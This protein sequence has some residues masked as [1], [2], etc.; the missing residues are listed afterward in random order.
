[1]AARRIK[2]LAAGG[3][4]LGGTVALASWVFGDDN[5]TK[6][7]F[8]H[9]L[10]ADNLKSR[11]TKPLPTRSEQLKALED[12]VY[13]VLVIG[14]GATGAG[15]ALDSVSRGLKTAL[16]ELDDFSSGT[17]SR[18]TKLLHGGVRYLQKAIFNL[19]IEQYKM[20]KEALHERANL[21]EIA[22]HL[23][24]PL[25]I[26]LPVYTWWQIPYYWSGIKMYDLVAGT[27]CIKSS[28]VLSKEKAIELF[29]MLRKDK[30]C[31]A[32]VY[33]DGQH[34]DA[35]MNIAIALTAARL[36]ATVANHVKVLSLTKNKDSEGQ[37]KISG[38]H[39][40]DEITGKEW[41]VRAK[42]V[43]N[44]TGPFTD[45]IREMDQQ[46]VNKI[47]APSAGVHIV[48]PDYYSP[49]S[50][51]L[52][53]PSTSDGRVIFFL[54]WQGL[55]IAGTTDTPCEVTHHP[56]PTEDDIEFI[57]G[58]IRSYLS[59]DI[60]VRR[61][62]V[63]SAWSGIRPLV[64]DPNKPNSQSLVRNHIVHVSD[65]GLVTIAGGKWTTYRSM[66]ME[67]LDAAVKKCN[68]PALRES[69][70]DGLLLEGAHGWTP[71]MFIRLVQ[72]FGLESEVAK[73]LSE[74]YGDRAFSV[75]KLAALTGKRWPIVGKRLHEEFPYI[76]A[77]VRYAVREYACTAIDV[78]ARRLRLA[79]LNVQAAEE[80][81]PSIISIMAEELK[82]SDAEQ[83]RQY[84]E[85][86]KFL[87]EE[88]GQ[89]VNR[90]SRDKIPINLSREEISNY[91]KRFQALDKEKKGYISINDIRR[92]L[93]TGDLIRNHEISGEEIH[94]A[95]NKVDLRLN[96]QTDL[97]EFIQLMACI[98]SGRVTNSR[99]DQLAQE[100][101][102][103]AEEEEAKRKAIPVDRSGGGV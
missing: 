43:I 75:A 87:K 69:A 47:C 27:K 92:G 51:G 38:A 64:S 73:H 15:C 7:Q 77:E 1:M 34:N 83:K 52:L 86:V 40:R 39:V 91:I 97:S 66:A 37:E 61:G 99:F 36:G 25:P 79:F 50:M 76:D 70:T 65:S 3:I 32:I 45:S 9:V 102:K 19:D 16:V 29:P 90:Q 88:M 17:S 84:A 74:T 63:L 46:T 31:G 95:L 80:A 62:D 20:V 68:L 42:C 85:A 98:K 58:E 60:E 33:Y 12:E 71:T 72:D 53:D 24:Y 57:L 49:A 18:S 6:K 10:A 82:W 81:L 48:L 54:P 5:H 13:D 41:D 2:K 67:T 28:Y 89:Q 100:A 59:P 35:R 103:N 96:G 26:M 78:I 94:A 44:A 101:Q 55:T 93:K 8:G 56:S 4:A 23:S 14:G 22:P 21:L 11:P 30:L